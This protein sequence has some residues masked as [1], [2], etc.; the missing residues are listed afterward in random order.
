MNNGSHSL[1]RRS[2][3]GGAVGATVVVALGALDLRAA[4]AGGHLPKVDP[5]EA[6]AKALS[7]VHEST[8]DGQNC[9]NC[10]LYT[11]EAGKEWG[12][13]AIFP[14]QEVAAKG[15]CSSWVVKAGG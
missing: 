11:G 2:F 14:G 5:N 8:K 9:A 6:K 1:S 15:W 4:N 3:I 13:C 7:Y 12:P 10:Q